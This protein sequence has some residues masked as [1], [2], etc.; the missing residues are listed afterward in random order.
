MNNEKK[1]N[2]MARRNDSNVE[3]SWIVIDGPFSRIVEEETFISQFSPCD[4][5]AK[6]YMEGIHAIS[7]LSRR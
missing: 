6:Y 3:S 1:R 4:H 2:V 5:E 7:I